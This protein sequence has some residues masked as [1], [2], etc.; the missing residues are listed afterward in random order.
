ML[1]TPHLGYVT[2]DGMALFYRGAVEDVEAAG[3]YDAVLA[4]YG[5]QTSAISDFRVNP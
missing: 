2:R 1:A 5:L 4:R 3:I